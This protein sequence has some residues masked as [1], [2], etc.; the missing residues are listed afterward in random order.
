[1][2]RNRR[3][4]RWGLSFL[5]IALSVASGC[6]GTSGA[7]KVVKVYEVKGKVLL[8]DGKPLNGGHIYFMPVDGSLAPEGKIESD[9]T[10]SLAT[11]NSG[12]GAPAG[13]YKVRL[14]P[15]D[16]SLLAGPGKRGAAGKKLPFPDKYL[17]EDASNL[18]VSVKAEPNQLEPIQL[19]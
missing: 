11:A 18:K 13:D 19:K 15:S 9:G 16:P 14:E 2:V 10:F 4:S 3:E 1:M 7:P 6:G 5:L 12:E 8:A 17:D